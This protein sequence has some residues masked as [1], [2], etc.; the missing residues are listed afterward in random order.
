MV[1]AID[2]EY[3]ISLAIDIWVPQSSRFDDGSN[4]IALMSIQMM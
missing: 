2:A 3:C 1:F 4:V